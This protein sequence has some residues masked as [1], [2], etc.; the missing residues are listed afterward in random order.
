M[1]RIALIVLVLVLIGCGASETAP[2]P[3]PA[4]DI[5]PRGGL[6]PDVVM[7]GA[8]YPEPAGTATATITPTA[9]LDS[10]PP[11]VQTATA[12]G[13]TL[14]PT[15]TPTA[16]LTPIATLT[17]TATVTPTATATV[18]AWT[19]RDP[20]FT[21]AASPVI[22][23]TIVPVPTPAGAAFLERTTVITDAPAAGGI[24]A[25]G[26]VAGVVSIAGWQAGID[27]QA[28]PTGVQILIGSRI[29]SGASLTIDYI[30]VT[31]AACLACVPLQNGVPITDAMQMLLS[32]RERIHLPLVVG[33]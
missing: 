11:P 28:V 20:T 25:L 21:P 16:N 4:S 6:E 12:G 19:Q 15:I 2:T 7:R 26:D 1:G 5:M 13:A 14:T 10:Y 23:F 8:P 30:Q 33:L 17:P 24:I 3:E 32:L 9:T 27:Y 22:A 18:P 29:P 31:K